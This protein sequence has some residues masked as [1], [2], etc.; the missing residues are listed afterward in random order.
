MWLYLADLV[1]LFYLLRWLRERQVVS[2][3][4]D[5]YVLIT[6][7]DSGFGKLLTRQLDLRGLRVLAACLTEKGDKQLRDQTSDRLEIVIL[8]VTETENITAAAQWVKEH[9]GDR[10]FSYKGRESS[11]RVVKLGRHPLN[12]VTEVTITGNGKN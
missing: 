8:D 6:G 11:C 1:G 7:C 10:G 4:H 5:K 2:H 3:L 9:V 12:R